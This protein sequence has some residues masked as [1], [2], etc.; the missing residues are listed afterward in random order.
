MH[1]HTPVRDFVLKYETNQNAISSY[2]IVIPHSIRSPG[3]EAARLWRVVYFALQ[4]T[5]LWEKGKR[6]KRGKRGRICSWNLKF[7]IIL[8]NSEVKVLPHANEHD[9]G[10]NSPAN[11][12]K[13]NNGENTKL[14][15]T[16]ASSVWEQWEPW[17]LVKWHLKKWKK[18]N[19]GEKDKRSATKAE[20]LGTPKKSGENYHLHAP[21]SY[22]QP[23]RGNETDGN[24][25][26]KLVNR[27]LISFYFQQLKEFLITKVFVWQV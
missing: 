2:V 19:S 21:P 1:T 23:R 8:Y 26:Y 5:R 7:S 16:A 27:I 3:A 11:E 20:T 24:K 9:N 6:E 10:E 18:Q 15:A 17:R 22:T 25:A 12:W 14:T 13:M 4:Y